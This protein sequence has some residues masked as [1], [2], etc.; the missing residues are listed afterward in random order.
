MTDTAKT[1]NVIGSGA[2]TTLPAR[3]ADRPV[4]R[5]NDLPGIVIF[6]HGV[7]DPGANYETV[8][9]GLCQGLNDRLNR[10]DMVKGEYGAAY[11][12]AK[13]DKAKGKSSS[14]NS[15]LDDPDTYLYARS[16]AKAHS[17]FIPFYWGYRAAP[18]DILKDKST[19]QPTKLRTQY[20][21][22]RGNRLDAHFGKAGG[23]FNNATTNLPDMYGAGWKSSFVSRRILE[24]AMSNYQYSGSSPPRIYQVL[25]AQRMALLISTIREVQPDETITIMAHSQGTMIALL[26]QAMLHD[27]GKRYADCLILVDSPYSFNEDHHWMA[28]LAQPDAPIQTVQAKLQTLVNVVTAVTKTPYKLPVL[29]DLEFSSGK[30]GGR[31]GHDWT[32]TS[33]K[34]LDM[35]G[36]PITFDERDNRGRVYLYFCP[37]DSTVGLP[38]VLGIGKFGIPQT[39]KGETSYWDGA[40]TRPQSS[41][42]TYPA[43]T[44]LS[45]LNFRQRVWALA[46]NASGPLLVGRPPEVMTVVDVG[47]RYINGD[48]LKPPF[49]PRLHGGEA[50]IGS[51]KEAPDAVTQD[52]A[53]GNSYASFL[54]K[55][56]PSTSSSTL[57]SLKTQ[58]NAGKDPGDQTREVKFDDAPFGATAWREETPNEALA[59]MSQDPKTLSAN[60]DPA[61]VLSDNSYHSAILRDPFNQRWGTA[62][63]VAIGQAKTLDIADWQ[64]LWIAIAD[65]KTPSTDIPR[66]AKYASLNS[67]TRARI[68]DVCTYYENGALP[69]WTKSAVQP[70]LLV[71]ETTTQRENPEKPMQPGNLNFNQLFVR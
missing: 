66:L 25:A 55:P 15:V 17:V 34:R 22:V 8:E 31:A 59:R 41:E 45:K 4:V 65:W 49:A 9:E 69:S 21:D 56:I 62:M 10:S 7:N 68:E 40:H 38:N 44:T 43:M 18:R 30:S 63:D 12:Q 36:K 70:T 51:G 27:E 35:K 57:D 33:G 37:S 23:M 47:E 50:K 32:A 24:T 1:H 19:N 67:E 16:G 20:Q 13:A 3:S 53:L 28:S 48:E 5:R 29:K 61:K 26:A 46:D 64:A 60:G 6:S 11:K 54:W 52:L 39:L 2:A 71:S 42:N 58:F 14:Q